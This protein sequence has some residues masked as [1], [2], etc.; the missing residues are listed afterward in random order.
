MLAHGTRHTRLARDS[1]TEWTRD[2]RRTHAT[3]TPPT[4]VHG[5]T[6]RRHTLRWP[7]ATRHTVSSGKALQQLGWRPETSLEQTIGEY[8]EW[9]KEQP[10]L[11]DFYGEIEGKMRT[12]NIIRRSNS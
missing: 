12:A 7:N 10:N 3:A 5:Q 11:K 6:V 8:I 4:V 1:R 9:V 2:S